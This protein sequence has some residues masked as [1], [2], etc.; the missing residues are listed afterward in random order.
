M[1]GRAY[2]LMEAKSALNTIG[3]TVLGPVELQNSNDV[4]IYVVFSPGTTAGAIQ[5]EESH[6]PT[7]TGTWVAIG[8][9][10][11]WAVADSVKVLRQSGIGLALRVKI[12]TAVAGGT[13]D[14]WAVVK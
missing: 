12:T 9:A 3:E 1:S 6:L 2:K 5:V 11:A 10:I 8:S 4:T 7:F 14:V 13:V